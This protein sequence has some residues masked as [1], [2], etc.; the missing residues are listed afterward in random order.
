MLYVKQSTLI[1]G[2]LHSP[3]APFYTHLFCIALRTF[4]TIASIDVSL[5]TI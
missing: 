3:T 2:Y 4:C 5:F 1:V